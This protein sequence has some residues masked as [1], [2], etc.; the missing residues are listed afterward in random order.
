[1]ITL[2]LHCNAVLTAEGGQVEENSEHVKS[3][4]PGRDLNT[5]TAEF[6][7]RVLIAQLLL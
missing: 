1:M 7:V 3:A 2:R 4:A 5:E 6:E